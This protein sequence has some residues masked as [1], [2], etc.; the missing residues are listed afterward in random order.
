MIET[1]VFVTVLQFLQS[2][3]DGGIGQR[4][5]PQSLKGQGTAYVSIEVTEDKLP[6]TG[7]VGRHDDAVA[8]VP[9][10]GYHLYLLHRHSVCLVALVRLHLTGD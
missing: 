6:F 4:A 9:Q 10:L 8:L 2:L 5:Y 7:T 1:V 3:A